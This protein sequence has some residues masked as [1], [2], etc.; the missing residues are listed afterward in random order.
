MVIAVPTISTTDNSI[1]TVVVLVHLRL[2]WLAL[3]FVRS[4]VPIR[5]DSI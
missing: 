4:F 2:I 5:F 1:G 3:S